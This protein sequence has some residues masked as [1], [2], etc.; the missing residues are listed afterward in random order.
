MNLKQHYP[1]VDKIGKDGDQS[2]WEALGAF[3]PQ[4]HGTSKKT[5]VMTFTLETHLDSS[6]EGADEGEGTGLTYT[7]TP[8]SV[9]RCRPPWCLIF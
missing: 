2:I 7:M 5:K 8:F 6:I 3:D 4:T 1:R 9:S